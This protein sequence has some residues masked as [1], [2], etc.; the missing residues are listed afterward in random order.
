M[1]LR[2]PTVKPIVEAIIVIED[3]RKQNFSELF[4]C[5]QY[6]ALDAIR[7]SQAAGS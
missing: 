3:G 7:L 1:R 5:C 6:A 4:K 2:K